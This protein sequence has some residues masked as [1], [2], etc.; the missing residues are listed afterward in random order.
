MRYVVAP[1]LRIHERAK[2]VAALQQRNGREGSWIQTEKTF[3]KAKHV[4]EAMGFSPV[5]EKC[6]HRNSVT[7][8]HQ[9]RQWSDSPADVG[10]PSLPDVLQTIL[11]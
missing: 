11:H 3:V 2:A 5:C 1:P 6:S 7:F 8:G 10:G 9:S 4:L